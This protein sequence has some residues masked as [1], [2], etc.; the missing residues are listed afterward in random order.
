VDP[1]EFRLNNASREG[2]RQIGGPAFR[3]IGMVEILQATQE[4]PHLASPVP[5][6]SAPGRVTGRGIAAGTRNDHEPPPRSATCPNRRSRAHPGKKVAVFFP[7]SPSVGG[8]RPGFR[9]APRNRVR[10]L[11]AERRLR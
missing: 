5:E 9:N 11:R 6:P 3:R 8:A 1:V 10:G 4:H 2:S 7:M